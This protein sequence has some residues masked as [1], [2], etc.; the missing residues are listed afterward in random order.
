MSAVSANCIYIHRVC[1][2]VDPVCIAEGRVKQSVVSCPSTD[3]CRTVGTVRQSVITIHVARCWSFL[4][5][6]C[7]DS[8]LFYH[9]LGLV[10]WTSKAESHIY[11]TPSGWHSVQNLASCDSHHVNPGWWR[12]KVWFMTW[13]DIIAYSC[14]QSLRLYL[15][16]LF[17]TFV[18]QW[19]VLSSGI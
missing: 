1:F 6:F 19:R 4:M 14:Y 7:D 16:M 9:V 18:I 8:S 17:E 12:Q 15:Q 11:Y 5:M 3:C 13:A 2:L 10:P